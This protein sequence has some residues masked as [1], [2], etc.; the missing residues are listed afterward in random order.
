[1]NNKPYAILFALS[2]ILAV[3]F[4]LPGI[5]ANS[6]A[7]S[8][9]NAWGLSRTHMG[10]FLVFLISV[11]IFW[12]CEKNCEIYSGYGSFYGAWIPSFSSDYNR[13]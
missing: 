8:V 6:I 5:Q 9:E 13:F 10:F 7:V 4:C 1:M 3:G 2:T 12:R 11:I